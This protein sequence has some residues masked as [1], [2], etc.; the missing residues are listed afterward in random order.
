MSNDCGD[1]QE[2]IYQYLDSELDETTAA[3]VREHLDDCNG[4]NGSFDFELRLKSL[5]RQC[6][7]EEM[8]ETLETKV[9]ELLRQETSRSHQ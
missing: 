7:T 9:R 4:C 2:Q 5:V 3:S 1:A 6:L 8:P